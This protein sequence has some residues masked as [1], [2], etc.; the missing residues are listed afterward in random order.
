MAQWPQGWQGTREKEWQPD[1]DQQGS[2]Q[3]YDQ[4]YGQQQ[5]QCG[6]NQ[7]KGGKGYHDKSHQRWK[8]ASQTYQAE[9]APHQTEW[10][11]YAKQQP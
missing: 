8:P 7:Q 10:R 11:G 3:G 1:D 9:E 4:Q 6:W 2:Y 5:Q